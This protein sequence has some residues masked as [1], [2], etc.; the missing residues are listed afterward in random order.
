MS[1]FVTHDLNSPQ[2]RRC[3]IIKLQFWASARISRWTT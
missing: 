2:M 1:T 3:N